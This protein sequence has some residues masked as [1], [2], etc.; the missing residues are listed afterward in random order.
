MGIELWSER[1]AH[2]YGYE[3]EEPDGQGNKN[4]MHGT[5]ARGA[6]NSPI[7]YHLPLIIV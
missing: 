4:C 1:V 2:H 7:K 3:N 5:D 6:P